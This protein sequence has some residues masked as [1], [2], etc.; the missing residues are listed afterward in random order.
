MIALGVVLA[1]LILFGVGLQATARGA[2][3]D[4][5]RL[6]GHLP[7]VVTHVLSLVVGLGLLVLPMGYMAGL[8]WHHR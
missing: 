1:L 5:A 6:V 8:L 4:L 7:W 2:N 3:D